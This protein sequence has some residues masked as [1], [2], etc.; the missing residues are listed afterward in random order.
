MPA[1]AQKVLTYS[2][3]TRT[4]KELDL[5]PAEMLLASKLTSLAIL[6]FQVL[7][8]LQ[9]YTAFQ[10]YPLH[11]QKQLCRV[12]WYQRYIFPLPAFFNC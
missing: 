8:S 1:D 9:S 10:D 11:V 12:G 5:V 7:E 6:T 4:E 3:W 2:S